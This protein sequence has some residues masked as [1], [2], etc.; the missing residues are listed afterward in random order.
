M[1]GWYHDYA[2]FP[3]VDPS[4]CAVPSQCRL[5]GSYPAN[6]QFLTTINSR[7]EDATHKAPLPSKYSFISS[8]FYF[9]HYA[10]HIGLNVSTC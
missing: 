4:Y 5:R 1:F 9:A 7:D 2:W 10:L 6:M 3:Q 8:C